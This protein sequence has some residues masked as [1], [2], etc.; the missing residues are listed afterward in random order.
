MSAVV[1]FEDAVFDGAGEVSAPFTWTMP[2][3]G[4]HVLATP[5]GVASA[6]V[7]TC[8]GLE[9]P[10]AGRLRVFGTE[11]YALTRRQR[12]RF[13]RQV[14]PWLLPPALLSN[15]TLRAA[16]LLVLLHDPAWTRRAAAARADEVLALCGLERW[17]D[18]RPAQV[19]PL[20]RTRASLARALAPRPA[21]LVTDDFASRMDPALCARLVEVCRGQADAVLITTAAAQRLD[22][23]AD[24][25]VHMRSSAVLEPS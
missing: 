17:A 13:S 16:I 9:R 7:R 8:V 25:I 24:T 3:G 22:D 5:A 4:V 11:P 20:A 18:S 21:L 2:A 14:A 12:Q 6:V 1:A 19:P 10:V 15:A 23:V